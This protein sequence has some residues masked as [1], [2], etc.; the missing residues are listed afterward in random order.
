M[1]SKASLR[2]T[3][4]LPFR[5]LIE[6]GSRVANSTSRWSRNGTRT[7][8]PKAMLARSIFVRMSSGR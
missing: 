4:A 8:R 3:L 5:I 7:S 1:G 6:A 2:I